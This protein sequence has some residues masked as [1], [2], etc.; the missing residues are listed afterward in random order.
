[1]FGID[2][3]PKFAGSNHKIN[4]GGLTEECVYYAGQNPLSIFVQQNIQ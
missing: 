2:F 3:I 4:H 1:M